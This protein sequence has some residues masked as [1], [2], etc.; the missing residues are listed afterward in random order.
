MRLE[1]ILLT[2]QQT[3][4]FIFYLIFS[5]HSERKEKEKQEENNKV[6]ILKQS[7]TWQKNSLIQHSLLTTYLNYEHIKINGDFTLYLTKLN[8]I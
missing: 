1:R 8:S 3:F 4:C 6:N 5:F 7:K 2:E